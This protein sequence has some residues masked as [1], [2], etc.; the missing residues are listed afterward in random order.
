MNNTDLYTQ[1]YPS[2]GPD[3]LNNLPNQSGYETGETS[4]TPLASDGHQNYNFAVARVR[5]QGPGGTTAPNVRV[6]FRLWVAAS[7]DTD[8][9]P[10]T[11]Y[12]S[13]PGTSGADLGLPVFPL[14]SGTGLVDPTGQ[15]LQTIPFFATNSNGSNDYNASYPPPGSMEDNNIQPITIPMGQDGVFA[16]FGCFLDVYTPGNQFKFPGTHH[17]V[18]AQIAYD[19]API[20]TVTP[21]GATPSPEN[22]DQLAQRNLQITSSGQPGFPITHRIPQTFDSRPSPLPVLRSD[23]TLLNLPDELM[24]DWGNTPVG[25]VASIYW[26][27][28]DST[29]VLRIASRLYTT[30]CLSAFDANTIQCTVTGKV[31]YIPVPD[32]AGQK[33]AGL[34]TI[35]LPNGIHAGDLFTVTVRRLVSRQATVRSNIPAPNAVREPKLLLNWRSVAGT[36]EIKIPVN[37]EEP[38]LLPEENTL[39]IMKWRLENM[40]TAYRWYPVVRRYVSYISARVKGMGGHPSIIAPSQWGVIPA[41]G[42]GGTKPPHPRCEEL[43]F[44]GKVSAI[45]YNRFGD[46]DGFLLLT[47]EGREHEFKAHETEV[48]EIVNRAWSERIMMSVFVEQEKHHIPSCIV[49]RGP[50]WP[51]QH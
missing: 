31:T 17:C 26:P 27:Q 18:V 39:A 5:L 37:Y 4:V 25:S 47:V 15:L 2:T 43:E 50:S 44:T 28:V 41:G 24:I 38:L 33:F 21:S 48:K 30:H 11:T 1:P 19:E 23:G 13:Q 16:Y 3:P 49:L 51:H 7:F 35:D 12:P 32:A 42:K 45:I 6:F 10:N 29:Q 8:F 40:S 36:F 22:W 14:A 20:P 34:F 46:F 9:D